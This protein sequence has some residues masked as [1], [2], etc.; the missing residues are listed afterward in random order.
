[1]V[2]EIAEALQERGIKLMLYV[3]SPTLANLE[4]RDPLEYIRVQS[5]VVGEIG[6]RYGSKVAGFWFD[7]WY[8]AFT[9]YGHYTTEEVQKAARVG[10]PERIA[11]FNYWIFP[12]CSPWQD[13]WAGEVNGFGTRLPSGP[14]LVRGAGKGYSCQAMLYLE[15]K[16]VHNTPNSDI[17]PPRLSE[18]EL[19]DSI[20]GFMAMKSVITLNVQVYQDG[21]IG[22]RTFDLLQVAKD[23]IRR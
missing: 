3:N 2:G 20:K 22:E 1:L 7:S 6:Q 18:R 12:V 19:I 16:W 21:T 13:Y 8:Q 5:A 9:K 15:E 17:P 14:I 4:K 10:N 11:A 23:A